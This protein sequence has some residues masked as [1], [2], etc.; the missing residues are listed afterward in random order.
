MPEKRFTV[1]DHDIKLKLNSL[2]K[3]SIAYDDKIVSQRINYLG[4]LSTHHFEVSENDEN[5]SY[6]ALF[7]TTSSLTKL[8]K[9]KRNNKLIQSGELSTWSIG[10][11]KGFFFMVGIA[12]VLGLVQMGFPGTRDFYEKFYGSIDLSWFYIQKVIDFLFGILFLFF[13]VSLK[14]LLAKNIRV[15]S[16]VLWVRVGLM[17]PG[18][19]SL[20]FNY[21]QEGI[22]LSSSWIL[23][24]RILFVWMFWFILRNCEVLAKEMKSQ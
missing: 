9:L 22:I 12:W 3:E 17:I 18:S 2:G 6:E 23:S 15:I 16:G 5:V 13:A 21:I 7:S 1:S 8:Y 20:A 24:L 10:L 19:L 11:M 14:N 4:L